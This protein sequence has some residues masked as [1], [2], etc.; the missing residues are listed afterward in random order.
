MAT[1]GLYP[2]LSIETDGRVISGD[3]NENDDEGKQDCSCEIC[4]IEKLRLIAP[5]TKYRGSDFEIEYLKAMKA[6]IQ[7]PPSKEEEKV[8]QEV[9][10]QMSDKQKTAIT[11]LET[12]AQEKGK[13]KKKELFSFLKVLTKLQKLSRKYTGSKR[14]INVFFCFT[15]ILFSCS[16]I[17]SH[18]YI[19]N[20]TCIHTYTHSNNT[21][22]YT[23]K[24]TRSHTQTIT[25]TCTHTQLH[26]RALIFF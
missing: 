12:H 25:Q 5:S 18:I 16:S 26:D 2:A 4:E 15:K 8:H 13:Y 10:T 6:L 20:Q 9:V 17:S 1:S 14:D 19:H 24:H 11:A 22:T 21:H 23:H 3:S 7:H